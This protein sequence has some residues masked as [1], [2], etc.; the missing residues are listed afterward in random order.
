M[1]ARREDAQRLGDRR[2][3]VVDVLDHLVEH[4]DVEGAVAERQVLSDG[5]HEARRRLRALAKAFGVDVDAGDVVAELAELA[6]VDAEPAADIEDARA[7]E[8]CVVPDEIQAAVL[9]EP[10]DE[11][12]IPEGDFRPVGCLDH[13]S[14]QHALPQQW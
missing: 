3:V 9:T 13:G 10:P 7:F 12:W 5:Q 6:H 1:A 8:R 14:F 4:D 2:A 11:A